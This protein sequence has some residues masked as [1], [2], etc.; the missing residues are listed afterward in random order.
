VK[1]RTGIAGVTLVAMTAACGGGGSADEGSSAAGGGG[2][3]A[4]SSGPHDLAVAYVPYNG[5]APTF[6]G[7]EKGIYE[8]HDVTLDMQVAQAPA[9]AIASLVSGEVQIA[10]MTVVTLVT[11]VSQ[12]TQIRCLTPVDGTV[13]GADDQ[14][15]T[16]T[17]VA[18]NSPV[19]EMADLE[20]KSV[21]VVAL[22]SQNHLFTLEKADEAGID[23]KSVEVVQLPFPQ[24]QQALESGQV[25]A[26]VSTQPFTAQIQGAGGRVINW[27][28]AELNEG[29]N[30]T[31]WA[32]SAQFIEENPEAVQ[33]FID[34]HTEAIEYAADN[35]EEARGVIPTFMELTAEQAANA[36]LGVDYNP[37]LNT[38]SIEKFMKLMK[39]H[40]FISAELPLEQLVHTP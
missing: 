28:E 30:G 39:K 9:A 2:G 15:S 16:A 19:Q 36:V 27:P 20:G 32:T 1:L 26:V 33:A 22:G 7:I 4:A 21:G 5:D 8:E 12:G 40:G 18:A 38:D 37:E 6:L 14:R 29:G 31:C 10:F 17:M 23:P 13:S 34:A 24:M 25:D 11:A 35:V 3:E